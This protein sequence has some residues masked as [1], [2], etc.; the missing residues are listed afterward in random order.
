MCFKLLCHLVY[1]ET[2]TICKKA[3]RLVLSQTSV[4]EHVELTVDFRPS[5]KKLLDYTNDNDFN[6]CVLETKPETLQAL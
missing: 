4:L 6:V 5:K 3:A 1:L 2:E